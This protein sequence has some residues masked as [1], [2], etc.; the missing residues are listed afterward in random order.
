MS[1]LSGEALSAW[2]EGDLEGE[3]HSRAERHLEDCPACRDALVELRGVVATLSALPDREPSQDLWPGIRG[4]L[5]GRPPRF[6]LTPALRLAAAVVILSSAAIIWFGRRGPAPVEPSVE[7]MRLEAYRQAVQ[8]IEGVL[9]GLE[10]HP[11]TEPIAMVRDELRLIDAAIAEV[12]AA[13]EEDP[14]RAW[15]WE[16]LARLLEQ[17]RTCLREVRTRSRPQLP[18]EG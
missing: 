18:L 1:H 14:D 12:R 10:E 7:L 3:E 13:L 8:D 4:Q 16:R 5:A 2:I 6:A 17:K 15:L 11:D 9:A